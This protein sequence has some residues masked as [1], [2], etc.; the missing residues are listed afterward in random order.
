[1]EPIRC[2]SCGSPAPGIYYDL[3]IAARSVLTTDTVADSKKFVTTGIDDLTPIFE[4]LGIH[5]FCCRGQLTS[6]VQARN[7]FY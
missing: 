1:M 4:S 3:F 6:A 5:K 2:L 7:L